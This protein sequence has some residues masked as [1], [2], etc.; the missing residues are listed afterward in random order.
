MVRLF[1]LMLIPWI[2]LDP[3]TKTHFHFCLPSSS[4]LRS[5][6]LIFPLSRKLPNLFLFFFAERDSCFSS[7]TS[8]VMSFSVF[9][10]F[11]FFSFFS[12]FSLSF[13]SFFC[14]LLS[15]NEKKGNQGIN[16]KDRTVFFFFFF[17]WTN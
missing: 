8:L 11:F 12:F 15:I 1:L 14:S 10:P 16:Y 17:L 5:Y 2:H 9:L 13:L 6:D 3:E 4:C 7:P